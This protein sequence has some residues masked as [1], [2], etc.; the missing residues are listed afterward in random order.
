MLECHTLKAI[1]NDSV[2]DCKDIL[3][4]VLQDFVFG[5]SLSNVLISALVGWLTNLL[6]IQLIL[7]VENI[8]SG[9]ATDCQ[10]TRLVVKSNL[11]KLEKV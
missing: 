11:N 5:W 2:S 10:R 1:T 9:G 8:K 3:S 6:T 4:G 7:F